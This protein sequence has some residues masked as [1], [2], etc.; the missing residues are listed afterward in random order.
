MTAAAVP[1]DAGPLT[2]A[3]LQAIPDDRH[4][5]EL[6]DGSLIVTPA[7]SVAHQIAAFRVAK[8]LDGIPGTL[9]LPAPV[10]WLIN[11]SNVVEPDVVLAER[12]A[13]TERALEGP[14]LL[15]VEVLSPSTRR[16][17]LGT[18]RQ[19]YADAGAA[20]YWLVD[21]LAPS[22]TV[23]HLTG[24]GFVC[25]AELAGE[26]SYHDVELGVTV[27]PANLVDSPL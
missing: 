7:P 6:I 2:Y 23:L 18:K 4:R 9:A 22:V 8:L 24:E 17:D 1:W 3:D 27:T 5:Y 13:F 10:D 26:D 16:I 14:P 11:D 25:V 19:L 20:R 21:P 12:E 15:V